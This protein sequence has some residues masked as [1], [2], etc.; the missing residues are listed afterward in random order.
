M[1]ASWMRVLS[2]LRSVAVACLLKPI[3]RGHEATMGMHSGE[4]AAHQLGIAPVEHELTLHLERA[5]ELGER[6]ARSNGAAQLEIA[7]A[8]EI[9]EE[10][11]SCVRTSTRP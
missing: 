11:T 6:A 9:V 7:R 3:V 2:A 4:K 8:R 10:I 5:H 1:A